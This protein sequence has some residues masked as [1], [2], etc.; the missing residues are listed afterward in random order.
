MSTIVRCVVFVCSLQSIQHVLSCCDLAFHVLK[1]EVILTGQCYHRRTSW[2][3]LN[4]PENYLFSH[5]Q[6]NVLCLT[7]DAA[8]HFHCG[9]IPSCNLFH[10]TQGGTQVLSSPPSLWQH[11]ICTSLCCWSCLLHSFIQG[12]DPSPEAAQDPDCRVGVNVSCRCNPKNLFK[13]HFEP[14]KVIQ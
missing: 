4:N 9:F 14:L 5:S 6:I 8:M 3:P 2:I 10:L 1:S 11:W 7:S 12:F 13:L